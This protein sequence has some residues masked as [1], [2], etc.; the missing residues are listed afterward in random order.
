[1]GLILSTTSGTDLDIHA[2]AA[3][4]AQFTATSDMLVKP[5]FRFSNLDGAAATFTMKA[6]QYANDGTTKIRTFGPYYVTKESAT[7]VVVGEQFD[8]IFLL[9]GEK[10]EIRSSSSNA[11]DTHVTWQIKW[12]NPEG[13]LSDAIVANSNTLTTME[14]DVQ[15]TQTTVNTIASEVGGLS[16]AATFNITDDSD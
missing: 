14:G 6:R 15:S 8:S 11:S 5:S 9:S 12:L 4:G 3:V 13:D 2:E 10:L 7:D 16:P 1:M